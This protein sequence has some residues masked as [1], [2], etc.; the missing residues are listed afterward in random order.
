MALILTYT[1]LGVPEYKQSIVYP[2]ILSFYLLKP[3]YGSFRKLGVPFW[4]PY[5]KGLII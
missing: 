2:K 1:I 5:N 4:G 3:L